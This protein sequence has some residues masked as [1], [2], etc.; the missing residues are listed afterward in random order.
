VYRIHTYPEAV[1][2]I[3]AV[4]DRA[5]ADLARA[6]DAIAASPWDGPSHHAA[7]P[8]AEVRHWLFGPDAA[9]QVIYL[10]LERDRE[11]HVLRVLW[12]DLSSR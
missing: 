2:Q 6:L 9:G 7:N 3:A 1:A 5:L 4:P 11:V 12:L 8:A 10:V